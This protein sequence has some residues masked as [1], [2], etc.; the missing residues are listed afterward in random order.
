M[1]VRDAILRML[2]QTS[3]VV[4][5]KDGKLLNIKSKANCSSL[6]PSAQMSSNFGRIKLNSLEY[7]VREALL[8]GIVCAGHASSPKTFMVASRK[9]KA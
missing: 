4:I 2:W 3:R 8:K 5:F 6:A 1:D 7:R 9:A